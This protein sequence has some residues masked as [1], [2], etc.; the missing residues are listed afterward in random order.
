MKKLNEDATDPRIPEGQARIAKL[1]GDIAALKSRIAE[2]ENNKSEIQTELAKISGQSV[3]DSQEQED[4]S[5]QNQDEMIQKAV[6]AATAAISGSTSESLLEEINMSSDEEAR[7]NLKIDQLA[8]QIVYLQEHGG[9]PAEV[10]EMVKYINDLQ[11]QLKEL[12][13]DQM[14]HEEDYDERYFDDVNPDL[15]EANVSNFRP[16]KMIWNG[17]E[18]NIDK[19]E[20][21]NDTMDIVYVNGKMLNSRRLEADGAEMV[22]KEKKAREKR[23]TKREYERE[24]KD[25][26]SSLKADGMEISHSIMWDMAENLSY[27]PMVRDYVARMWKKENGYTEWYDTREP[28]KND[29]IEQI[30]NDLEMNESFSGKKNFKLVSEAYV[31]KVNDVDDDYE[32]QD[33]V[34]YV[35]VNE[36]GNSFIGKIFKVRPDGDWFGLVK[37]GDSDTFQKIS[38]EPEYDEMDIVEFLG[39]NYDKVEIIDRHEYNDFI[40]DEKFDTRTKEEGPDED[41]L[42]MR[43]QEDEIDEDIIGGSNWISNSVASSGPKPRY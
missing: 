18:H 8:D 43:T 41:E 30:T 22:P 26:V 24:L 7:I 12:D 1:D 39:E 4:Q 42:D 10:D 17:Q 37:Q 2:L 23:M 28:S 31:D 6:A 15:Y 3:Q 19:V 33:Y 5:G 29:I 34:F 16:G 14:E 13:M 25:V 32:D 21:A 11:D 9:D 36:E 27:D 40:E 20:N 38:Y 35:K